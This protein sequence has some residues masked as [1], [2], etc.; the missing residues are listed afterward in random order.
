M[1][2]L[3]LTIVD[4]MLMALLLERAAEDGRVPEEIAKDALFR[5]LMWT[6]A[7]RLAHADRIRAASR[8]PA[9]GDRL[10]DS[11]LMIWRLRDGT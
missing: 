1:G 6:P 7:E 4:Q 9:D 2:D 8:D 5:G 10:E 11:T 3:N